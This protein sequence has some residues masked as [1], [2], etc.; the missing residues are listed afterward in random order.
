MEASARNL[1]KLETDEHHYLDLIYMLLPPG[2]TFQDAVD[3]CNSVKQAVSD[4][5]V[6]S[7]IAEVNDGRNTV[8]QAQI[9]LDQL[10]TKSDASNANVKDLE[11]RAETISVSSQSIIDDAKAK[12]T[13]VDNLT[14]QLASGDPD[15]TTKD[16]SRAQTDANLAAADAKSAQEAIDDASKNL[17]AAIEQATADASSKENAKLTFDTASNDLIAKTLSLDVA[18]PDNVDVAHLEEIIIA[19]SSVLEDPKIDRFID[20]LK[21]KQDEVLKAVDETREV[22]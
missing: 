1:R 14:S 21:T 10:T 13:I 9:V 6:V 4:P 16:L 8:A 5:V 15:V 12:Q 3:A 17:Q 19:S 22:C 18:V 2:E 11:I 20:D 7:L